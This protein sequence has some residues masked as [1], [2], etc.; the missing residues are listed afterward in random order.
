[1][2][3]SSDSF[4]S[5]VELDNEMCI[6]GYRGDIV[7]IRY[8]R[9]TVNNNEMVSLVREPRN[10]YDRN[11]VRVDNVYGIQV[12]HIKKGLALALADVID[13]K[14]VR[15]EGV[16][17]F[18][19]NNIYTMPCDIA[20][21]GKPENEQEV[22]QR[23]RQHG[24]ILKTCREPIPQRGGVPRLDLHSWIG[25]GRP[26]SM[27]ISQDQMTREL[28]KLFEKLG[29]EGKL[30]SVEPAE[31]IK[32][33]L[34]LHQKQALA[35]MIARENCKDLPPFWKERTV[36]GRKEYFN[37]ATN[38]ATGTR[39]K[40]VLGGILADDMG[41]GKTLEV[42][43][44]IVTNFYDGKPL[45][46]LA[47]RKP[48][49]TNA[50]KQRKQLK[51]GTSQRV[52]RKW[53]NEEEFLNDE[54]DEE[55]V[56]VIDKDNGEIA[57]EDDKDDDEEHLVDVSF[58]MA[59]KEDPNFS[60][61]IDSLKKACSSQPIRRSSRTNK[62]PV[63]YVEAEVS[64]EE[65]DSDALQ[66]AQ[67]TSS[68]IDK[69]A[70]I[71]S[72]GKKPRKVLNEDEKMEYTHT[73]EDQT[74]PKSSRKKTARKDAKKK[75]KSNKK[76]GKK[77]Q[78]MP[79]T[80]TDVDQT[81]AAINNPPLP[82]LPQDL[83]STSKEK[84]AALSTCSS[85]VQQ[86]PAV[87][88]NPAV[89]GSTKLSRQ[90]TAK[91]GPRPTLVICPLSVLSNWQYQF[92]NHVHVGLLNVYTYYGSERTKDQNLLAEQDVVLTTYQTLSSE[93]SK[94]TSA[95]IDTLWL[96]VVLDE[97]HVIRNPNALM[98]KAVLAL[99]S[100]RRWIITGT[101]IQNSVKDMFSII[102]FLKLE[103]FTDRQW[104][105]RTME[106][107][108]SEGDQSALSRLQSLMGSIALR[109]TKTQQVNGKPLVELPDRQ[110]FVQPVELSLEERKLYDSMAREGKLVIGKYF[111]TGNV[112]QN[113]AD[114]LAILMRLRQLCCHPKLC[115]TAPALASKEGCST[116][117]ELRQKLISTLVTL[118]SSGADEECPVCLDSLSTPVI[119]HC[120]HVFCRR[121]IEDVIKTTAV[122]PRCP[123]CRGNISQDVLVEVPPETEDADEIDGSEEWHSSSKIDTL[124]S[125]L[126]KLRKEDPSVKSLVISQ[127]T[128]LLNIVETPLKAEGFN[129]VRLDGK[130]SQK[131]RSEV[132][133]LF[134]DRGPDSPK[135]MLLSLKAGGVGL[136]LTAASR[137]FLLDPAWNPAAEDQC[138]DRCHRLGQTEDVIV[139]K[140]V[141]KDSVEERMLELQKKKR[142]L[143]AGAFNTKSTA[144]DRRQQRIRDVRTL[145]D[146]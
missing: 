125:L 127:F 4:D 67:D 90:E 106:R 34:F 28:D 80:V 14:L 141:E 112:L 140:F 109:R 115:A 76:A 75:V 33:V 85:V 71:P 146:F 12:G 87:S 66:V 52:K 107:P 95:L 64:S 16:V 18:G 56:E 43:S 73:K 53:R 48:T 123:L 84:P 113:Y 60:P 94:K 15:V 128:S 11:A 122:N 3:T 105:R 131:K 46:T 24:Y 35:W 83:A 86:F 114:V 97:G 17:P 124:M 144:E 25:T 81:I 101:P 139:T 134:D 49:V 70:P 133:E 9:G 74:I 89:A 40:C 100:E 120:A 82:S 57:E 45:V 99:K 145:M 137:V 136:N 42:I 108:I 111:K 10:P 55:I 61:G 117:E 77:V 62:R 23:M 27:R 91:M 88:P 79:R 138:F 68:D 118:L 104:W 135:V 59:S 92:D 38:Y 41:L 2:A 51:K 142:E 98:S 19:K 39:P 22:I 96:R 6:G 65:E 110:V 21:W 50:S 8:Y 72:S 126:T 116:P 20:F 13:S 31:A 7:G 119:T 26:P 69:A 37:T 1:M 103:P 63:R 93:F 102:S 32:S 30:E 5:E 129:F 36:G 132:I 29:R 44:L 47:N 78:N 130:M 58:N 121:C 143:M 54:Y